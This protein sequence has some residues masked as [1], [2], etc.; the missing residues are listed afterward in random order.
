M[1]FM[2]NCFCA[3]LKASF[4]LHKNNN[5][6]LVLLCIWHLILKDFNSV[7]INFDHYFKMFPIVSCLYSQV[8]FM[9]FHFCSYISLIVSNLN[10]FTLIGLLISCFPRGK[11]H[12]NWVF[13]KWKYFSLSI[14]IMISWKCGKISHHFNV[15]SNLNSDLTGISIQNSQ[16]HK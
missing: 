16:T 4:W 7:L 10:F 15:Q 9:L 6:H 14:C 12:L 13:I 5:T 8:L 1:S 2:R 11:T 3:S